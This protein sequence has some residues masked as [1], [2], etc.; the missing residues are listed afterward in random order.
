MKVRRA[1]LK[2]I[3]RRYQ[4]SQRRVKSQMVK[5]NLR[6]IYQA[7]NGVKLKSQ[8]NKLREKLWR[9]KKYKE[10]CPNFN[11]DSSVRQ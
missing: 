8:I 9:L 11:L 4:L 6:K 5:N 2:E 7:L 1:V 10:M 3:A